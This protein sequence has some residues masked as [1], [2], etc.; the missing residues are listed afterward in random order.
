MKKYFIL[1][2][3]VNVLFATKLSF[4]QTLRQDSLKVSG[5][6][7]M[8]KK[9]IEAAAAKGG[10]V[11]AVWDKDSKMLTFTFEEKADAVLSIQQAIALSGYDTRDVKASDAAYNKLPGCCQYERSAAATAKQAKDP[12]SCSPSDCRKCKKK[13]GSM[14]CCKDGKCSKHQ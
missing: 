14:E 9:T 7:G 5:N 6:C 3:F 10:A 1:I 12:A 2:V 8:C 11:T 13:G 4:S